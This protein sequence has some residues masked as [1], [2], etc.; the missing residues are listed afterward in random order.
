M[1][2]NLKVEDKDL[3]QDQLVFEQVELQTCYV[4]VAMMWIQQCKL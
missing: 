4:C 2:F 1:D 3:S